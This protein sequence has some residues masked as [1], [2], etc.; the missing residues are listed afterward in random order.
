MLIGFT[1][2]LLL[3]LYFIGVN[4]VPILLAA[5][6]IGVLFYV[7]RSR[8]QLTALSGGR[9]AA[10][11]RPSML[12]FEEIGGQERAKQELMEALEFLIR[13]ENIGSFGIRPLKG[14]LLTG[15]PGTGKTLLAKAAAQHTD[16]AFVA[17][18]GSEFV[19][20]YVGVGASR[21]RD[22]F[23]EARQKAQKLARTAP[24]FS[25]TKSM[26]SAASATADSIGSTIRH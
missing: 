22:L 9:Q 5:A 23:K 18:S 17:A 13:P 20:M 12:S 4:V 3:F 10:R 16:S 19:E 26:S 15:P 1:P 7:A 8:G 21:I 25:L 2:V 6:V 11:K 14:I 24:S